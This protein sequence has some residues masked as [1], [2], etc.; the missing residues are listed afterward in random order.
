[1]TDMVYL[2]NKQMGNIIEVPRS[3]YSNDSK[4]G[5]AEREIYEEVPP[6]EERNEAAFKR[7]F[8]DSKGHDAQ[9][10]KNDDLREAGVVTADA[11]PRSASNEVEDTSTAGKRAKSK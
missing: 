7:A 8:E 9:V 10:R 2:R 6:E 1:M 4:W 3:E 5:A 11:P